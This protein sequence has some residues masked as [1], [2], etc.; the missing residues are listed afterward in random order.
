[1]GICTVDYPFLIVGHASKTM[2]SL[3]G[4]ILGEFQVPDILDMMTC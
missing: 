4:H 3:A 1:M 2:G